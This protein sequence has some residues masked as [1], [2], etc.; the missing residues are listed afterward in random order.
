MASTRTPRS[1]ALR[2][3]TCTC[4]SGCRR[5]CAVSM[6]TK[7]PLALRVLITPPAYCSSRV[8]SGPRKIRLN[9]VWRK[10]PPPIRLMFCT[11]TRMPG[12]A[13]SF[14]RTAFISACCER[15]RSAS[16]VSPT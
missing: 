8:R 3:S 10:P 14:S 7:P 16:G 12:N 5:A 2:R 11:L 1:E 15:V 9:G 6:S 4:T 13:A